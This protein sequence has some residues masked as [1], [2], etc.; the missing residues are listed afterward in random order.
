M[1]EICFIKCKSYS[2]AYCPPKCKLCKTGAQVKEE[3]LS[4]LMEFVNTFARKMGIVG[5]EYI[6]KVVL[7]AMSVKYVS[8][9]KESIFHKIYSAIFNII[10]N[11]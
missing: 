6:T 10:R 7:T 8:N 2:Q 1:Y 3:N 5:P 11:H 4:T 9:L